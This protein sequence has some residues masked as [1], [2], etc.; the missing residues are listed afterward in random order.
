MG[1]RVIAAYAIAA[2]RVDDCFYLSGCI[3]AAF[4]HFTDVHMLLAGNLSV[5]HPKSASTTNKHTDISNLTARFCVKRRP[6]EH[7]NA[8][9]S[10]VQAL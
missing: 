10:G 8:L 6:V 9:L 1:S 4:Y 7:H 3:E 5:I 2:C